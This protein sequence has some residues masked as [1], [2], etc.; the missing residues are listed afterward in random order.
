MAYPRLFPL[1]NFRPEFCQI[2][3]NH[4]RHHLNPV[5]CEQLLALAQNSLSY[6]PSIRFSAFD[7]IEGR[8]RHLTSM[9]QISPLEILSAPGFY[10]RLQII[11][12]IQEQ[13]VCYFMGSGIYQWS[14]AADADSLIF[15]LTHP[16]YPPGWPTE[17]SEL[18]S[19]PLD[20]VQNEFILT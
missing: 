11:G 8:V 4:I 16:A 14:I 7:S 19:P 3:S 10:Q 2:V 12:Q 13:P 9:E 20:Q 15:W 6:A 1:E 5:E 17:E 18:P